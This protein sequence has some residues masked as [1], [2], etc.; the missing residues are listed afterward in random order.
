MKGVV[1]METGK[2]RVVLARVNPE[3]FAMEWQ[4]GGIPIR[5]GVEMS[6]PELRAALGKTGRTEDEINQVIQE[7][8]DGYAA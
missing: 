4:E 3:L 5:S 8:R 1:R 2:Y 6:E 7:A